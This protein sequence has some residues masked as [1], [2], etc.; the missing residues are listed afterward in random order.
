[1]VTKDNLFHYKTTCEMIDTHF[2][3]ECL[4]RFCFGIK[5]HTV[6]VL[7]KA[8]VHRSK[9]MLARQ[10]IWGQRGLFIFCLPPYSPHLNIIERMWKE[11]KARWLTPTDYDDDQQLFY[12]TYLI[13]SAIGNDLSVN[14]SK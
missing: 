6:I 7:D 4:D 5:K 9:A 10:K 2:I 14:F 3:T 12:A 8:G 13:L 1:M 11:L